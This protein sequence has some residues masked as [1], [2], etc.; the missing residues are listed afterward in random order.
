LLLFWTSGQMCRKIS[1]WTVPTRR[2]NEWIL[3]KLTFCSFSL[4][5][6]C[7]LE[8]KKDFSVIVTRFGE[9]FLIATTASKERSLLRVT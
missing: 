5:Q 9:I 4:C 7:L 8:K 3:M 1:S 2:F 6:F